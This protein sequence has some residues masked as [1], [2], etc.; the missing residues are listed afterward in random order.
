MG[1][2]DVDIWLEYMSRLILPASLKTIKMV[3]FTVIIGFSCGFVLAICL[4][5][6]RR[7][8]LRPNN[9]IYGSLDFV[10]NTIRSF[11]ILI[12]IVAIIPITRMIVGTTIGEKAAI[13]PLSISAM[14]FIARMLE[15]TFKEVDKQLIEAAK[16][17]GASDLQIVFRVIT[18]ESVPSMISVGTIAVINNIAGSTIAGAV[19]GGGL[20]A[21]ALNYG[22]QSFNN[23]ILYT[24]VVIL[25]IMVLIT[26]NIGDWLYKKSL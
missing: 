10:I 25:L 16:S 3:F 8:G 9:K 5:L 7:D 15:N 14:A 1:K 13:L 21:V 18:K 19:G 22:Y 11:P 2:T 20:G 4:T 6:F 17:F 23:V 12:L 24:S 26:Q